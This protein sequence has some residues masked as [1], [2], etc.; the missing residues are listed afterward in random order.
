[1]LALMV[2]RRRGRLRHAPPRAAFQDDAHRLQLNRPLELNAHAVQGGF[3]VGGAQ[4]VVGERLLLQV[5]HFRAFS[6][7]WP[8]GECGIRGK[9]KRGFF[10]AGT[11][12]HAVNRFA[13]TC[14]DKVLKCRGGC[15]PMNTPCPDCP[16]MP[17]HKK[18]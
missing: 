15:K 10:N 6:W 9:T 4:L 5:F 17:R 12:W 16:D 8:R 18:A 14:P 2:G 1:M 13:P 3:F 11:P 7:I